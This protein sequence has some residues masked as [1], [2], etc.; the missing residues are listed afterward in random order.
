MKSKF[1]ALSLL[2]LSLVACGSKNITSSYNEKIYYQE[3]N[4]DNNSFILIG[5]E[6]DKMYW[7][8]EQVQRTFEYTSMLN[9]DYVYKYEYRSYLEHC[10]FHFEENYTILKLKFDGSLKDYGTYNLDKENIY[11]LNDLKKRL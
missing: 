7:K 8:S 9:D 3:K 4:Q 6:N 11:S 2:S 10:F 5:F 1:L